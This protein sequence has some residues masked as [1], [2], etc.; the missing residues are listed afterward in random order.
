MKGENREHKR[1]ERGD[2]KKGEKHRIGGI[3]ET[4]KTQTK[5]EGKQEKNRETRR[6]KNAESKGEKGQ[7]THIVTRIIFE[8]VFV[9][10]NKGKTSIHSK[11]ITVNRL[12]IIVS[13]IIPRA[14]RRLK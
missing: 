11:N 2:K 4:K 5:Q 3:T 8:T 13:F 10:A 9:P 7:H 1:K 6:N 12:F 14:A